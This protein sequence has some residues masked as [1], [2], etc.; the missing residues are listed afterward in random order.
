MD[1]G[2]PRQYLNPD[3]K[4]IQMYVS[5]ATMQ[6]KQF[7]IYTSARVELQKRVLEKPCLLSKRN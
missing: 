1:D 4:V 3:R 6:K 5:G 2:P 7:L